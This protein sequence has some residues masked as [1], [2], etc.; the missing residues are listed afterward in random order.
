MSQ[1]LDLVVVRAQRGDRQAFYQIYQ[2]HVGR[3]YAV[4]WRL[5]GDRQKAE[6]AAQEIFIK[7]WEALPDFKGD[8]SLATWLRSIATRTAIDLWRKDKRLHFVDAQDFVADIDRQGG[9]QGMDGENR[10]L[11]MAIQR[12]PTQARAVFI[13]CALE[14]YQH[15]E[16]ADLLQ[17]AEGSSKAQYHRARTLLRGFLSED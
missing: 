7:V 9:E 6:D 3:V 2:E 5:L 11:E 16:I 4:C 14:G 12:L 13:L 1:Q 8:S 10:D 17:I 15:N